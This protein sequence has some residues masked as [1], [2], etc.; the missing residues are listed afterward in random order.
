MRVFGLRKRMLC[1]LV[2]LALAAFL[3]PAQAQ[4]STPRK[5]RFKVL[6]MNELSVSWKEP[7]GDFDRYKLVYN[8]IPDG[9]QQEIYVLKGEN[10]ALIPNFDSSKDYI[11]KVFSVKG[12]QESKP[13]VGKFT[14][15]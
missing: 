4:V 1:P 15:K 2:L 14:S 11:V 13:V 5:L 8:T 12:N 10:Q 9:E 6:G 3:L 7:R